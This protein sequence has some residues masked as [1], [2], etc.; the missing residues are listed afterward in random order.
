MR[1]THVWSHAKCAINSSTGSVVRESA[2]SSAEARGPD[3][4][5]RRHRVPQSTARGLENVSLAA[6]A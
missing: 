4:W 5:I 2:S 6:V 3:L 1:I